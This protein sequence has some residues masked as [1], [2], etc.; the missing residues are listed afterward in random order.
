MSSEM[1]PAGSSPAERPVRPAL[2][3][4]EAAAVYAELRAM[5][6]TWHHAH[7]T[8]S[9]IAAERERCAKICD[10]EFWRATRQHGATVA[11]TAGVCAAAIRGPNAEL[12]G[13]PPT[14]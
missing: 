1:P 4:R 7:E 12:T 6:Y 9:R 14:K 13:R 8:M 2:P 3:E 11:I 10:A 5:G